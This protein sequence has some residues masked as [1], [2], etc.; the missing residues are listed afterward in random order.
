MMNVTTKKVGEDWIEGRASSRSTWSK[1]ARTKLWKIKIHPKFVF[2][3][4]GLSNIHFPDLYG[5]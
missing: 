2:L 4:G 5:L 3:L 1:K